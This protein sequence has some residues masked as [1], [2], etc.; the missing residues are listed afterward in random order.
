MPNAIRLYQCSSQIATAA[1]I[2]AAVS[3]KIV[4]SKVEMPDG[5]LIAIGRI[6]PLASQPRLLPLSERSTPSS[7]RP[8]A[9][10]HRL[11]HDGPHC[12]SKVTTARSPLCVPEPVFCSIR[13]SNAI[14]AQYRSPSRCT[15]TPRLGSVI[16]DVPIH[17][18]PLENAC[19][20]SRPATRSC[21]A[22]RIVYRIVPGTND[23]A[24]RVHVVG[25][26]R[27]ESCSREKTDL[28]CPGSSTCSNEQLCRVGRRQTV[29]MQADGNRSRGGSLSGVPGV[30]QG[31][32]IPEW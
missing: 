21:T 17:T 18:F 30:A 22:A 9:D 3:R 25:V 10:G 6:S 32:A 11:V 8:H 4:T 31:S 2:A 16:A 1:H 14:R 23:T 5:V 29:P 27:I 26:R 19:A 7:I 12:G 20:R 24:S 15:T 28:R 13:R